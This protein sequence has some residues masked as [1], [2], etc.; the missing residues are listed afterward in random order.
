MCQC[1]FDVRFHQHHGGAVEQRGGA[2]HDRESAGHSGVVDRVQ[3]HQQ[4]RSCVDGARV[5][6]CRHRSRCGQGGGQPAMEGYLSGPRQRGGDDEDSRHR[7]DDPVG[8][9]VERD[10]ADG[11]PQRD[12]TDDE[13]EGR[14]ADA[15]ARSGQMP[16]GG[17]Q[18]AERDPGPG[19]ADPDPHGCGG[20]H[21]HRRARGQQRCSRGEP[22]AAAVAGQVAH[23]VGLRD[24]ADPEDQ[25]HHDRGD[26]IDLQAENTSSDYGFGSAQ[27][28]CR[29]TH[30]GEEAD[31]GD[32]RTQ[33][34][35]LLGPPCAEHRGE[36]CGRQRRQYR[37][38]QG[39]LRDS[40]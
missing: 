26:R 27:Q 12:V 38:G 3:A 37:G 39:S 24:R 18:C 30:A 34:H 28:Y 6:Q 22:T 33:S 40:A 16:V 11:R 35:E 8:G 13:G 2:R 7:G 36:Q 21:H 5:E 1:A 23:R 9:R 10:Q 19:P 31:A 4:Q 29:Q 25:Q 15:V 14:S 20:R 32:G 17:Q